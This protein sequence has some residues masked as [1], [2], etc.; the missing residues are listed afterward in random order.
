MIVIKRFKR[1]KTD[2]FLISSANSVRRTAGMCG[3]FGFSLSKPVQMNKVFRILQKL[4]TEK[5]PEEKLPLGGYGAGVAVLLEDGNVLVE[6]VGKVD[7]SPAKRLP[8]IVDVKNASVLLGHVRMPSPEFMKTAHYTETAQ[9]YIVA[10]NPD[11][12]VVSI[13][14]GK[15]ENY[16]EVRSKLGSDHVF[17][18]EKSQLIDSEVIPHYFEEMIS[19]TEDTSE[20]LYSYFCKLQGSNAI[21]LLQIGE[22]DSFLHLIHKKKTRGL[23]VWKN[24]KNEVIFCSR[25]TPVL[26]EFSEILKSGS[27]REKVDIG[28]H[29]DVGLVLSFRLSTR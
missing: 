20:T 24:D 6:K 7:G 27:F 9:P 13:H 15:M 4:E 29:E 8:E 17:D 21:A 1:H 18:S 19:E 28:Y 11:L 25:K 2:F 14:N 3:I 23:N 5:L 16:K 10:R 12:T 26:D 22:E